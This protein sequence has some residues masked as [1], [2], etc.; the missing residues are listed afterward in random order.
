MPGY[1]RI[2]VSSD[3]YNTCSQK[4]HVNDTIAGIH[5]SE[6]DMVLASKLLAD[7]LL[8]RITGRSKAALTLLQHVL[9]VAMVHT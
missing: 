6:E 9:E 4:V 3:L 1:L 5:L 2:V 7:G 8:L